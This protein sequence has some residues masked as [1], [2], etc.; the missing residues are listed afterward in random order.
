MNLIK[1]I[2]LGLLL[3]ICS[4]IYAQNFKIPNN[5]RFEKPDDYKKY[6]EDI[7]NCIDWLEESP[8]DENE[9]KRKEA[10]MFLKTWLTGSP[11]VTIELN[12][13]IISFSENVPDLL[14]IFMG[15]WTKFILENPESKNNMLQ[16]NIEGLKSVIAVYE[17]NRKQ[18]LKKDKQL[19]KIIDLENKG[20]LDSW[21]KEQLAK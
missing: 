18:G 1:T 16:G 4:G 11:N 13:N 2:S 5:Y 17:N 19:E 15:G 14:M 10:N 6:E 7:I 12:S 21:V 3:T 9:A 8:L 20:K